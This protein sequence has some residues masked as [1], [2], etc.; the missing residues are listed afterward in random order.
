MFILNMCTKNIFLQLL[1]NYKK[2]KI[3][4]IHLSIGSKLLH[5]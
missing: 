5:A 3:K 4:K 2:N 1:E